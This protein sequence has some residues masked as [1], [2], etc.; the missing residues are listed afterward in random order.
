MG[1]VKMLHVAC[2][3][4]WM[5]NLLSLTRLMAHAFMEE[6]KTQKDI[7]AMFSRMYSYI[8]LPFMLLSVTFGM[9]L[10]TNVDFSY[11]PGW[12]HMK[13]TLIFLMIAMDMICGRWVGQFRERAEK[14]EYRHPARQYKILHSMI[15][16]VMLM[17]LVSVYVVRD[18][19]GEMR[20]SIEKSVGKNETHEISWQK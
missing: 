1:I 18:L 20:H 16:V 10:I 4:I 5:G 2:V 6:E 12:F 15:G 14:G 11:K 8:S 19:D 13:L 9:I 17:I 7:A 3:M